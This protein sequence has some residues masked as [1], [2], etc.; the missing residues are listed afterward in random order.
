MN[1]DET[2]EVWVRQIPEHHSGFE[3]CRDQPLGGTMLEPIAM[4]RKA[5]IPNGP[6]GRQRDNDG[7]CQ[8]TNLLHSASTTRHRPLPE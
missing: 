4:R 3:V 2:P 7:Q 1:R 5:K 6:T 8:T